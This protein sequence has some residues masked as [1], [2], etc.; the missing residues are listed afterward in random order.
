MPLLAAARR[1]DA[2]ARS[3]AATEAG[4]RRVDAMRVDFDR[5]IDA[6]R[7]AVASAQQRVSDVAQRAAAAAVIGSLAPSYSSASMPGT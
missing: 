3:V 5:V 7:R 2:A 1:G 6:E 4:R